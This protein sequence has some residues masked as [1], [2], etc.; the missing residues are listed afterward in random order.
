MSRQSNMQR[1]EIH[2]EEVALFSLPPVNVGEDKVSWTEY[3]PSFM[4][5]GE[6]SSIQFNIL[7]NSTQ[8]VDLG[9][10]EL[11]IRV[12]IVKDDGTPID[13]SVVNNPESGVPIDN[14][15]HSMWSSVDIK[16]NHCLA[17][18]SGT[19]YMYKALLETLLN[20]DYG[21]KKYQLS[22]IGFTGDDGN[23]AQTHYD[24]T[25]YNHGLRTRGQWF[26][27]SSHV[28][29]AGPLLADIC[30]Q[31]RLILNAVD[32]DIKLWPTRDEFRLMTAPKELKCKV[33]IDEVYLNVCKVEVSP[34]VMLGHDAGLEITSTKYPMQRTDI[35]T[36]N[37]AQNSYGTVLE[38]IWQGEVPSRLIVGM[39]KSQ[40]YS[41]D[42]QLNPYMF[43]HFNVS[44]VG[45][46]VNSEPTPRQPMEFDFE[47]GKYL[48]G[49]RS[50]YR[51]SGKLNENSDIGITR[52]NYKHGNCLIAFD[53][54]PTTSPDFR[55][56]G[57]PKQGH[58]KL[59][60]KF[61]KHLE[62]AV[63]VILY[64]TFPETLEIDR[65]RNVRLEVRD[66]L[67]QARQR[68]QK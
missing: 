43:E 24:Q 26:A 10:T 58:T 59:D 14:I 6:Y 46:Y 60:I 20:Y 53:V 39:V 16:M 18:T 19:D 33:I 30:N 40:A 62:Q 36:F 23:F 56:I 64:A 67:Q 21:A 50:L 34:V 51:V 54:D 65:E 38:D 8:Y 13:M 32:I 1:S 3:R 27:T 66:N 35:R 47:N 11:H 28:E 57:K 7:G 45:F 61:K 15:L 63:T 55:Y 42:F 41:G 37:V 9:R 44:S 52:E 17:S 2:T 5:S 68:G 12:R 48:E 31:E 4:T 49:Y 29:F 25:E 22:A